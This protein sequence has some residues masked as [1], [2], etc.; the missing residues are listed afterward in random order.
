MNFAVAGEDVAPGGGEV[1]AVD[2][3]DAAAD[4]ET[5]EAKDGAEEAETF[6]SPPGLIRGCSIRRWREPAR[7]A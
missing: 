2:A 5:G 4:V 1:V 6:S 3:V 7:K